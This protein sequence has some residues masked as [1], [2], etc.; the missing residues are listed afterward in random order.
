[1]FFERFEEFCV[2]MVHYGSILVIVMPVA[3]KGVMLM[4]Y[5]AVQ[6][7]KKVLGREMEL[8]ISLW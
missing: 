3:A 5:T 6:S 7:V 8:Y 1:M 4:V 2:P